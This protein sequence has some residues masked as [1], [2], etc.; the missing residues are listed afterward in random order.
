MEVNI[1]GEKF[2]LVP[3]VLNGILDAMDKTS[4]DG[5]EHGYLLCGDGEVTPGKECTGNEC[6][7]HLEDCGDKPVIGSFHSHPIITS[8]SQS[9][10]LHAIDR[11]K[12]HPEH[13]HLLCVS[14]LDKGVRCKAL[15]KMPPPEKKFPWPDTEQNRE[16]VKPYFTKRINIDLDQIHDLL[17]GVAWEDLKPAK[18]VIAVDEG[19]GVKIVEKS[20]WCPSPKSYDMLVEQ[21]QSAFKKMT[22]QKFKSELVEGQ[23]VM[24]PIE[25]SEVIT[26][27]PIYMEIKDIESPDPSLIAPGEVLGYANALTPVQLL[28]KKV[29]GKWK[30]HD[31]RHRLMAWIAAGYHKAPV[32]FVKPEGG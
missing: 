17:K 11:A 5:K 18:E 12:S 25:P 27:E 20:E 23:V 14:L 13:K 21:L 16:M 8:F 19:E 10:Y 1:A 24:V 32:V 15:K 31:G 26:P 3:E 28:E 29:D 30:I 9:D 22:G 7:I 4:Q 6:S 2:D